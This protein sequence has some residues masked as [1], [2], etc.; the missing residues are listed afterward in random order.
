MTE[1]S[2]S[3]KIQKFLKTDRAILMM[4]ISIAFVFWLAT[5]LSYSYKS[6]LVVQLQYNIAPNKVFTLPPAQ[7][8]KVDIEG[9]GWDLL[10]LTFLSRN[11]ILNISPDKEENIIISPSSLKSKVMDFVHHTKILHITPEKIKLQTENSA[12]KKIPII[13][14]S[15]IDLAVLHQLKDSIEI[16]PKWVEVTG[17]ASIIKSINNWHTNPLILQNIKKTVHQNILLKKHSNSNIK[18]SVEKTNCLAEVEEMT[19]KEVAVLVE[20]LNAPD[21]LL[22][23]ILPKKIKV[24]C[25]VGLSDYD[26]L[27]GEEFRA[28]IDFKNVDLHNQEQVKVLLKK[29]PKYIH[30]IHYK[31]QKVDFI[32]SKN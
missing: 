15:Q 17:P 23:V 16:S 9:T 24:F 14:D 28:V 5:K 19:E 13:L 1:F 25:S 10:G 18:F 26:R 30:N 29:R 22:L 8:L 2:N 31:P 21:S 12:T 4:C 7:Q 11:P 20:V 3:Q 6:S 27:T 32:L